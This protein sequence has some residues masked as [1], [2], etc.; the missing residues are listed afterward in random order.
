VAALL[1]LEKKTL[2]PSIIYVRKEHSKTRRSR[3][4][5]I[6]SEATESLRQWLDS[7]YPKARKDDHII[8]GMLEEPDL[9]SVYVKL[10]LET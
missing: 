9:R 2:A 10:R 1:K 7:K 6:T 4:V 8:F 5:F 3:T